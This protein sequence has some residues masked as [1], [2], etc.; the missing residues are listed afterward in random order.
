MKAIYFT[1]DVSRLSTISY[2][3]YIQVYQ[4]PNY[5]L[6]KRFLENFMKYKVVNLPFS[7]ASQAGSS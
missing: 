5:N 4:L 7:P 1:T 2:T 3:V 6:I